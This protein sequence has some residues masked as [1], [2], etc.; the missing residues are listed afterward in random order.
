LRVAKAISRAAAVDACGLVVFTLVL[1]FG[2]AALAFFLD[3][4]SAAASEVVSVVVSASIEAGA[5]SSSTVISVFSYGSVRLERQNA[6]KG[7]LQRSSTAHEFSDRKWL[8]CKRTSSEN[9]LRQ[10]RRPSN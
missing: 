8:C 3:F 5:M 1:G 6:T 10:R 2:F 9:D 7:W 4:G